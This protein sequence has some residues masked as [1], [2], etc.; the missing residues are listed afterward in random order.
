MTLVGAIKHF[1]SV[2]YIVLCSLYSAFLLLT[3]FFT[4]TLF[5]EYYLFVA[6]TISKVLCYKLIKIPISLTYYFFIS[7]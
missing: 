7:K 4:E 6:M 1:M 2:C 3:L 5:G